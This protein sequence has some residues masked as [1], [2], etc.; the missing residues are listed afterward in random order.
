LVFTSLHLFGVLINPSDPETGEDPPVF[1]G[2]A[3]QFFDFLRPSV[4]FSG[5]ALFLMPYPRV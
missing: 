5:Y 2:I 4:F 3:Q 1:D